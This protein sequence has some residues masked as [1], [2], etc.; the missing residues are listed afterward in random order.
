MNTSLAITISPPSRT[1]TRFK[2]PN[3]LFFMDDMSSFRAV[4]KYNRIRKYII[5]PEF[6]PKGRLHYHG[7]INMDINEY[8]RF[9]KHAIHKLKKIGFVDI[10]KLNSF[11]DKLR[12][13]TYMR[14]EWGITKEIL[15][16]DQPVLP[17][18]FRVLINKVDYDNPNILDYFNKLDEIIITTQNI[19][20]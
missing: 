9:H 10:K 16:I 17:V 14:K 12:W 2:E 18:K 6:D 5:Y 3:N 7:I 15:N 19:T 8:V 20:P 13:V 4:M 11:I 1:E